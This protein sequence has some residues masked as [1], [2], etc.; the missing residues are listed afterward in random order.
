MSL[1]ADIAAEVADALSEATA[2]TGDGPLRHTLRRAGTGPASPH[3][4]TPVGSPSD[5][6]LTGL[7]SEREIRDASGA[8]T[9]VTRRT[10]TVN[11]TGEAPKKT[12][13][14]AVGVALSDVDSNTVFSEIVE[15]F[16]FAP[17]GVAL[18]HEVDLAR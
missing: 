11:A 1:G 13:T 2:A 17:G 3:D 6:E 15:V 18:Y 7:E 5:F 14:I 10:L 4:A 12:D 9:G 8:L 16:T